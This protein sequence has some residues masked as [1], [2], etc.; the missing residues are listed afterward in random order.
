MLS[1]PVL[2]LAYGVQTRGDIALAV[3][4]KAAGAGFA[5]AIFL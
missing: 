3:N 2:L 4:W 1:L 5:E